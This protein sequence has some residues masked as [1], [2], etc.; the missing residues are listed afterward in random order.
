MTYRFN[1]ISSKFQGAF[2]TPV[3]VYTQTDKPVLK[4]KRKYQGHRRTRQNAKPNK[5]LFVIFI[6]KNKWL[7]NLR[8]TEQHWEPLV[9]FPPGRYY[10]N[11]QQVCIWHFPFF[12][13]QDSCTAWK[14][15]QTVE[16]WQDE[17]KGRTKVRLVGS[18][19]LDLFDP[20]RE[21]IN[22]LE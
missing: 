6:W 4:C 10:G 5:P 8:T 3:C 15:W 2:C 22:L 19:S 16:K 1:T 18:S 14:L 13:N 7:M 20:V 17:W 11:G 9:F 12:L 21:A